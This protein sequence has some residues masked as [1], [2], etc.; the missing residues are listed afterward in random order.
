MSRPRN[1]MRRRTMLKRALAIA[2]GWVALT[3]MQAPPRAAAAI[4]MWRLDCGEFAFT[5]YQRLLLRHVR[6][7]VGA[8][9]PGRQLLPDPPRRRLHA[10][11]HR[12]SGRHRSASRSQTPAIRATL[13][14]HASSTSSPG[15]T[16]GPS[17]SRSSASAI[18]I[19]IIPARRADFPHARLIMGAGRPRRAARHRSRRR[20]R[21]AGALA[22]RRRPGHRGARRP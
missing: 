20:A 15:S 7:S 14:R 5:D 19:S 6:I 1:E 4:E 11:G 13:A 22:D 2:L 12:H 10:L 17:R 3:G 21:A 16:S 8:E 9:G 18:I